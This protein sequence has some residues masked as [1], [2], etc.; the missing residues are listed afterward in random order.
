[1]LLN[2]GTGVLLSGVSNSVSI[3]ILPDICILIS[4]NLS[5]LIKL[6]FLEGFEIVIPDFIEYTV[7]ILCDGRL[8]AGFDNELHELK[9]LEKE[10]L[11][12]ILKCEYEKPFPSN[13]Q[14]LIRLEDEYI[15]E[16]AVATNSILFTSDEAL[17]DEATSIKQPV[18][19]IPPRFQKDIKELANNGYKSD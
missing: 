12:K 6:G 16:I 9:N 3:R 8:K 4:R 2:I 15:L 5:R 11:I 7:E 17:K 1:M 13:R 14:E 10:R 18:I 19:Y